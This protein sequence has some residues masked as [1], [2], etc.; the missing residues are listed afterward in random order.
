MTGQ[1]RFLARPGMLIGKVYLYSLNLKR[2][3]L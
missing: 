2:R 1:A 3:L